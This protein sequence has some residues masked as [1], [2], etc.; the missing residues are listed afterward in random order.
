MN[1]RMCAEHEQAA[2]PN[3]ILAVSE[4]RAVRYT[5]LPGCFAVHGSLPDA[6][7]PTRLT[8]L[9][10]ENISICRGDWPRPEQL[11][12]G[13]NVTPVYAPEGAGHPSVPT[14]L[15]F[16]RFQAPVPSESR[17][18]ALARAGYVISRTMPY[19]PEAAWLE[20]ISG[21]IAEALTN[22]PRLTTLADVE[23]V[24]PQFLSVVARR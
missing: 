4:R 12:P 23:A 22:L 3:E 8:D 1:N 17:R 7:L 24:T 6:L 15:V 16:I 9:Q 13:T 21:S 11:A 20:P 18:E 14:G 19:A 10:R 2:Y 5:R